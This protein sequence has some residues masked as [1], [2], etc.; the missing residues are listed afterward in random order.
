[1]NKEEILDNLRE[2]VIKTNTVRHFIESNYENGQDAKKIDH[3]TFGEA[4]EY[5]KEDRNVK[6]KD[7]YYNVFVYLRN[8][9]RDF[10]IDEPYLMAHTLKSNTIWVPTNND[11]FAEDWEVV[12]D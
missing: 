5:L 9:E 8:P 4:L 12:E 1:M 7:W 3:L 6:R 2:V 11:L 10:G